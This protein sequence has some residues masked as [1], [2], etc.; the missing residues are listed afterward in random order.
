MKLGSFIAGMGVGVVGALVFAPRSG[1]DTREILSEKVEEGKQYAKGRAQEI[2]SL[3]TDTVEEGKK[4]VARQTN[5]VAAAAQAAKDTCTRES[6]TEAP[7]QGKPTWCERINNN[8]D[9]E[10][11]HFQSSQDRGVALLG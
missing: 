11:T 2:R 6:Q 4:A 10:R 8:N 7:E 9:P 1:E 5:A 3:A